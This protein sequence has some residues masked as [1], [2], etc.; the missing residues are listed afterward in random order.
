MTEDRRT[1]VRRLK[2]EISA[3]QAEDSHQRP[4][5]QTLK[6][7]TSQMT[8]VSGQLSVVRG[9]AVSCPSSVVAQLALQ[10]FNDLTL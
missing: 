4:N 10:R 7:R 9:S 5:A 8:E 6:D 2:F 3:F 1:E